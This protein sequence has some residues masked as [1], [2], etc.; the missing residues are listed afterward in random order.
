MNET[1]FITLEK[2]GAVERVAHAQHHEGCMVSGDLPFCA[3]QRRLRPV[4]SASGKEGPA[5][6]ERAKTQKMRHRCERKNPVA[7]QQLQVWRLR[8]LPD[9]DCR[10]QL[11][12]RV[13]RGDSQG[14]RSQP[15]IDIFASARD[16]CNKT[17]R[18]RPALP[19]DNRRNTGSIRT[20]RHQPRT[21]LTSER[22]LQKLSS[23]RAPFG[24]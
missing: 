2:P 11:P 21:T 20:P 22:S 5:V 1:T 18:I 13:L 10:A 16:A 12:H 4:R 7:D 6:D 8:D 23:P 9:K 3:S 19:T 15:N 14:L 17:P 24:L